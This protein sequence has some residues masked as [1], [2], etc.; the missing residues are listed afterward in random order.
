MAVVCSHILTEF[1]CEYFIG[2]FRIKF[3]P[4]D[5]NR[6]DTRFEVC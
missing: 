5:I 1:S 3:L 2:P 6:Q 4:G